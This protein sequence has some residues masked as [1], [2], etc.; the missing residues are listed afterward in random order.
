MASRL[1]GALAALLLAV[2]PATRAHPLAPC[3]LGLRET[4]GGRAEVGWKTPLVH[5]RGADLQP[6]GG[7]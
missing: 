6:V 2:A 7:P 1:P 4:G 3:V 5:P